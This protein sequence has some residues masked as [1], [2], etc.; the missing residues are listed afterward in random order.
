ML[1]AT[2]LPVEAVATTGMLAALA[3][4]LEAVTLL[5]MVATRHHHP[6][7]AAIPPGEGASLTGRATEGGLQHPLVAMATWRPTAAAAASC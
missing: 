6:A 7:A 1:E 4:L 5:P 2:L 3:S